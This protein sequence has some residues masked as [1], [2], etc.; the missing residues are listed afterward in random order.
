MMSTH[1]SLASKP[2]TDKV[3]RDPIPM[4]RN[5]G[6]I[7]VTGG[8]NADFCIRQDLFPKTEPGNPGTPPHILKYRKL[9]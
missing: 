4:I 7:V 3:R 9:Q 6:K 2:P 8:S 1:Q 5:A